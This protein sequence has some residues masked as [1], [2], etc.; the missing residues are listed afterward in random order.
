MDRQYGDIQTYQQPVIP[1]FEG[2]EASC[3]ADGAFGEDTDRFAFQEGGTRSGDGRACDRVL[4][5]ADGEGARGAEQPAEEGVIQIVL[6]DQESYFSAETDGHQESVEVGDV[7]A[8]Q[9]QRAL[10]RDRAGVDDLEAVEEPVQEPE[11]ETAP[12]L[13]SGQGKDLEETH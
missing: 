8:H 5:G 4:E 10:G 7:V 12:G 11:G 1:L 9:E 6:P 3:A 13:G 2:M